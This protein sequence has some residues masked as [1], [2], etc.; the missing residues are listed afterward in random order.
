MLE[1]DASR[2][3]FEK[4]LDLYDSDDSK[5]FIQQY[6]FNPR[7]TAGIYQC[8][9]FF[10]SSCCTVNNMTFFYQLQS[11]IVELFE[12]IRCIIF[13]VF[14]VESE[15]VH[16]LFNRFDIF[17]FFLLSRLMLCDL[18]SGMICSSNILLNSS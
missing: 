13:T 9:H 7:M 3:H 5:V 2:E 15:P 4:V 8:L 11:I 12:I 16:I 14:P 1:L 17:N 6:A 18:S 10:N